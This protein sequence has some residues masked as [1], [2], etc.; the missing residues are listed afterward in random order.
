MFQKRNSTPVGVADPLLESRPPRG[1][2]AIERLLAEFVLVFTGGHLPRRQ[3]GEAVGRR[4][5]LGVEVLLTNSFDRHCKCH[6]S[7][8]RNDI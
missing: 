5:N 8:L 3:R 4:A 1:V 2:R 7:T 6:G